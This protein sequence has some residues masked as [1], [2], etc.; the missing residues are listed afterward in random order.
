MRDSENKE[1]RQSRNNKLDALP[2]VLDFIV[3]TGSALNNQRK[4]VL[5]VAKTDLKTMSVS[6]KNLKE[7]EKSRLTVIEQA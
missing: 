2:E 3:T 4:K 7:L 5:P 1:L 6:I